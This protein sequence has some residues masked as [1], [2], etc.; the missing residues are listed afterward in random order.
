MRE[1]HPDSEALTRFLLGELSDIE[2][3]EVDRHLS[4]CSGCRDR[5]DETMDL[6][7]LPFLEGSSG[8]DDAFDR[9]LVGVAEQLSG[10][11]REVRCAEDLLAELLREPAPG[12]QR[13]IREDGRFHSLKLCQL[14]RTRSRA[15]WFSD[16]HAA[17]DAA[18]LAVGV[19]ERFD[20]GRY[21][22]MLTSDAR[23]LSWGYLANTMRITSDCR[24][25]ER[26]LQ[27]AWSHQRQGSGDLDTEG[28]LLLFTS[29]LKI[30]QCRFEEAL[31]CADQAI[32]VQRALRDDHREGSALIHKGMAL[33]DEG[34]SRE[35]IAV[36]RAGLLRIDAARDPRLLL[37]GKQNLA[38]DLV[39]CGEH[40]EAFRLITEV[41]TLCREI[42]DSTVA[43]RIE[44][45]E[46]CFAGHLGRF[47]EA[48]RCLNETREFFVHHELGVDF[49][50]I[51]LHLAEVHTRAGQP[52]KARELLRDVIP[53]GEAMG[54]R[55]ETL[56][57]RLLYAQASGR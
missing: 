41:R 27:R 47:V 19:A 28:E 30:L 34:R 17:R 33:G 20:P 37:I 6:M 42:G 50:L 23:A 7:S 2:S 10:L 1:Q 5:A 46:G 54:L 29:S 53:M 51:S 40:G 25:A 52:R 55:R 9:A 39:E 12:R 8:Y 49:V 16:T 14:L 56:A 3:A 24:Q 45:L 35:A 21:G 32:A 57:A 31:R 15:L 38:R 26:A 43:A 11:R 44:W 36:T 13:K 48:E 18:E 22:A 4:V